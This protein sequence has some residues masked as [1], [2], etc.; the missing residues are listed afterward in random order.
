MG[1]KPQ[2]PIQWYRYGL[3]EKAGLH[4][5]CVTSLVTQLFEIS[6]RSFRPLTFVCRMRYD[7]A[8]GV[9]VKTS[10]R[11]IIVPAE[12]FSWPAALTSDEVYPIDLIPDPATGHLQPGIFLR[13][14]VLLGLTSTTA[15]SGKVA[16]V[17]F[18][19]AST[20]ASHYERH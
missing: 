9:E 2:G 12:D 15:V 7:F 3:G 13:W 6:R 14:P 1:A 4:G 16:D 18:D 11:T 17:M 5:T 20:V 8:Y 10:I 19:G